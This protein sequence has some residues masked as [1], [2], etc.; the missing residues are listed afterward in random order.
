MKQLLYLEVP[1]P[2]LHRVRSW[3][4]HEFLHHEFMV[5]EFGQG[6]L[7]K[8]PTP[9]GI[10]I[11]A[12]QPQKAGGELSIFLWSLQRT[13]YLKVFRWGLA[14]PQEQTLLDRLQ[15]HLKQA[16][17]PVYPEPPQ[18]DLS[19]TSIFE[20][21]A[22]AYPQTVKYFQ[23]IPNGEADLTRVY[24]WEQRWREGVKHPQ[25]PR[26][27]IFETAKPQT[28]ESR[29]EAQ[30]PYDLIYIGVGFYWWSVWPLAA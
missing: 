19:Q 22:E 16:F 27:V 11:R 28:P 9:Q 13:T 25:N 2:D 10:R 26:Q 1:T 21:L 24:W 5:S 7:E 14:L 30:T 8:Q 17:P 6:C 12:L 18:I 29:A 15:N 20:A 4:H 23:K 3:L